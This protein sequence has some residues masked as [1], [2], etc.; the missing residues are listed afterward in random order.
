MPHSI[1]S[2]NNQHCVHRVV[3]AVAGITGSSSGSN[4]L[5]ASQLALA[6]IIAAE[7]DRLR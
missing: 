6:E 7:N 2:L 4:L 3:G 5:T 1:Y